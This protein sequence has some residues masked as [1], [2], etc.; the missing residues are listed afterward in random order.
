MDITFSTKFKRDYKLVAKRGWD[1]SLLRVIITQL[2]N[3]E[4]LDPKHKDHRL[5]GK[6]TDCRECHIKP[7]W[8]LIYKINVQA[9]ALEL[10]ATGT[11]S[12]LF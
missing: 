3:S 10:V 12:D 5:Q 9:N 8:L 4:P 1:I 11:H 6:F 7:D 2:A